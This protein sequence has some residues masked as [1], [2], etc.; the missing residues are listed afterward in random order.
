MVSRISTRMVEGF[1]RMEEARGV[2]GC[3]AKEIQGAGT[4][5]AVPHVDLNASH[6]ITSH[7]ATPHHT[8]RVTASHIIPP[9]PNTAH[10]PITDTI[11]PRAIA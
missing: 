11:H 6:H 8:S 2:L 5:G 1:Y 9:H 10:H 7:H 4:H 3:M